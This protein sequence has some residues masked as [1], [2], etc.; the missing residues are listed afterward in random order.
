M[1]EGARQANEGMYRR[2]HLSGIEAMNKKL[3]TIISLLEDNTARLKEFAQFEWRVEATCDVC[4]EPLPHSGNVHVLVWV[5]HPECRAEAD[6]RIARFW[7]WVMSDEFE[8]DW[9]V[10][11]KEE[12]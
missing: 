5:V 6:R 2:R 1:N 3:D 10:L 4:K 12:A 9:T 8:E 7:D 11:A